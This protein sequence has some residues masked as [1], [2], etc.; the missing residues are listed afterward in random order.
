MLTCTHLVLDTFCLLHILDIFGKFL[1][2]KGKLKHTLFEDIDGLIALFEASHLSIE[3]EH[4]LDEAGEF[5]RKYLHGWM[6]TFHDHLLVKVVNQTLQY[7]IHKSLSRF[8][9][10]GLQLENAGWTSSLHELSE[11]DTQMISYL[12]LKEISSVSK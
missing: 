9:P 12:H 4:S 2:D 8:M 6:S 1:D 11:I 5:C 7:P 3:G 10:T